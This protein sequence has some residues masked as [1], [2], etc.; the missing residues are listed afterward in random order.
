MAD[1]TVEH[2]RAARCSDKNFLD[3]EVVSSQGEVTSRGLART[4]NV[5]ASGLLLETAQQF[6]LGQ[7]LRITLG[8]RDKMVQLI[9]TVAH[10]EP[11]VAGL[12]N[13]GVHFLGFSAENQATYLHHLA[14]LRRRIAD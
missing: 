10:S 5:S 9:G 1:S 4:L 14:T 11:N 13:T 2:R 8:L 3:F 6:D 12:F 7:T